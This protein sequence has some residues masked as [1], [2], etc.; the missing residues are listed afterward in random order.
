M[1]KRLVAETG[2][3]LGAEEL[4]QLQGALG[5]GDKAKVARHELGEALKG[6]SGLKALAESKGIAYADL[7]HAI[8]EGSLG[9]IKQL[10]PE[11]IKRAQALGDQAGN[12]LKI[13]SAEGGD[14]GTSSE[15]YRDLLQ[16]VTGVDRDKPGK[17]DDTKDKVVTIKGN[18][19]L[20]EDGTMEFTNVTGVDSTPVA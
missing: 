10:S 15:T 13:G 3:K 16:Q 18:V 5:T 19:T 20:K 4:E 12:L 2:G 7:R 14:L 8:N 11:D 1:I 6:V 9:G 17:T